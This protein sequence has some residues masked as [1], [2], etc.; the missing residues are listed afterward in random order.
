M[1]CGGSLVTP[2]HA[3]P[4][5]HH[6]TTRVASVSAEVD[7]VGAA[8]APVDLRVTITAIAAHH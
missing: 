5:F 3:P 7:A 6:R 2:R 8:L 4:A 1:I